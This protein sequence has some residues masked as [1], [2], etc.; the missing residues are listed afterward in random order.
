LVFNCSGE[1]ERETEVLQKLQY[2]PNVV[3]Y[4]ESWEENQWCSE[5]NQF[6]TPGPEKYVFIIMELCSGGDLRQYLNDN[7]NPNSHLEERNLIFEQIINGL[8]HLHAKKPSGIIHR[9][10]KPENIFLQRSESK[11]GV[12]NVKIGD[13]GFSRELRISN[14]TSKPGSPYYRAPEIV[15]LIKN[16]LISLACRL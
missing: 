4:F 1:T 7:T 13:F 5:W 10:L 6:I 9:D 2:H 14:M 15:I 3:R 12:T 16:S 8:I 11:G